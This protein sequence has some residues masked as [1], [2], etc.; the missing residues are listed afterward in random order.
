VGGGYGSG[1]GLFGNIEGLAVTVSGGVTTIYVA[2]SQNNVVQVFNSS[3]GTWTLNGG[4]AG[5][6]LNGPFG[7]A[8]DNSGNLYETDYYGGSVREFDGTNW[9]TISTGVGSGAGLFTDPEGIAVDNADNV[10]C[11]DEKGNVVQKYSGGS[12]SLLPSSPSFKFIR[13]VGV[14]LS[15]NPYVSDVSTEDIYEFTGGSWTVFA[16]TGAMGS[17]N[18]Q[19]YTPTQ[20]AVDSLGNFFVADAGN[21]RVEELSGNGS[22]ANQ[23]GNSGGS[24]KLNSP[25]ALAVD[26]YGNLYVGDM[27]DGVI[28]VYKVQ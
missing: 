17:A 16:G 8:L 21:N 14:D 19:F 12:W 23:F 3:T 20:M 22:Y 28:K 18:G 4:P 6:L 25:R 2:D 15:G 9:T 11:L 5:N 1:P 26:G 24:G 10:Y 7:L 13:N 27:G